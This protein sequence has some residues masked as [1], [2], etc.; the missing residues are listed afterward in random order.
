[1]DSIEYRV[2]KIIADQ[3]GINEEKIE[4][5]YYFIG[6]LGADSLEIIELIMALEEDFKIRITD[7]EAEKIT[8]VKEAINYMKINSNQS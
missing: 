8:T 2:K 4:D 7:N 3:L 1:M 6:D 5:E